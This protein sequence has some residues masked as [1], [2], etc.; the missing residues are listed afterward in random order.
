M[1]TSSSPVPRTGTSPGETMSADT[2]RDLE[3]GSS[4]VNGG[5]HRR[6]S[7]EPEGRE[8]GEEAEVEGCGHPKP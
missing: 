5:S 1:G 3:R 4:W 2:A 6:A 7:Q 8:A